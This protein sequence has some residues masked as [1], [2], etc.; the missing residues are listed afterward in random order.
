[1]T[2]ERADIPTPGEVRTR[3]PDA[4]VAYHAARYAWG[5]RLVVEAGVT[6]GARVLDVGRSPLTT[7]LAERFGR[8]DSLGLD[9]DENHAH[10]RHYR[11]DLNLAQRREDWRTD[12]GPY[13]AIVMGEVLEH[14]V[15]APGRVLTYLRHLLA[16]GGVLVVQTPNAA[17]L[18]KRLLLLA[19]RQPYHRL[20]EDRSGC[21][22]VREYTRKEI[23][24]YARAVGLKV[25][26]VVM[27]NYFDFRYGFDH[28]VA[29][30]TP[31]PWGWAVNALYAC[32]PPSMR[33]GMSVVL[34][35][36]GREPEGRPGVEGA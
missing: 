12:L 11:F 25:E 13:D 6:R 14:L 36:D 26:R 3:F 32:A 28:R 24:D 2:I 5:V 29:A 4:Y 1:M 10:G 34:R 15:T 30:T 27:A 8:A 7:L 9:P 23:E 17:A 31:R 22:H 18:H 19:G 35:R 16:P 33:R 21:L 20:C